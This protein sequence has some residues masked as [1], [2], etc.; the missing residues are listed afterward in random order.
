M[1]QKQKTDININYQ[2]RETSGTILSAVSL[3]L[4]SET[5]E[6]VAGRTGWE[7][8]EKGKGQFDDCL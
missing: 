8:V 6:G 3:D 5:Q 1:G 2:E 4:P 7:F